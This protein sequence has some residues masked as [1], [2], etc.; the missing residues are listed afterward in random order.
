MPAEPALL[1]RSA[2]APGSALSA[3]VLDTAGAE[4]A[5]AN[6][7][8]ETKLKQLSK[9]NEDNA[10]SYFLN[11]GR[12]E[13]AHCNYQAKPESRL[14]SHFLRLKGAKFCADNAPLA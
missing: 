12:C 7:V 6:V 4:Q 5:N 10:D 2:S 9:R 13:K 3:A 14:A 8:S 1:T 11:G